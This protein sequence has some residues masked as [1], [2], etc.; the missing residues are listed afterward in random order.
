MNSSIIASPSQGPATDPM[1]RSCIRGRAG[2]TRAIG[3]RNP[4]GGGDADVESRNRIVQDNLRLVFRVARQYV[5]RGLTFEDLV[6]EGNLGLIRAAEEYNP[7][8]GARFS[9]YAT[10]WIR[11][12]IVSALAN[13]A[14]TIRLPINISKML[15]R[16]RRIER[17]LG[18]IHGQPPTFEEVA[19]AMGLDCLQRRSMAQAHRAA[20]VQM[21][22]TESEDG[23]SLS[24]WML[25]GGGLPE[26]S[27]VAEE[28]RAWAFRRL[29]CLGANE[30]T[31]VVLRYGLA[32]E[33]PMS[34][35]QIGSRL[36]MTAGT[37][38]K[39]FTQ[40]LQRLGE[41][42]DPRLVRG[43]STYGSRVG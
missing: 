28:E 5:N 12:A 17:T 14:G 36:S 24:L 6:G 1:Q 31:I 23:R 30:R 34:L 37:V 42:R 22:E 43:G 8:F 40:A 41:P 20:R 21:D 16:W 10:Y 38:Q 3:R 26:D 33:A 9:T 11:E 18:H 19:S 13:T 2:D 35:E 27:L 39:L 32:S 15:C 29:E 25:E 7:S 4:A